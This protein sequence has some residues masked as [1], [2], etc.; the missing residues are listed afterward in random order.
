MPQPTTIRIAK[1]LMV[2]I[3][4]LSLFT[5]VMNLKVIV[6]PTTEQ[7]A[8]LNKLTSAQI[9]MFIITLLFPLIASLLSI[10]WIRGKRRMPAIM[11]VLLVLFISQ[12]D[13]LMLPLSFVSVIMLFLRPS[14]EYFMGTGIPAA[15]KASAAAV[16]GQTSEEEKAAGEDEAAD[17]AVDSAPVPAQRSALSKSDPV[18]D[19]RAVGPESAGTVHHLMMEA[20]EE[21]RATVPPSSA[22]DETVESVRAAM[23]QGQ[24]AA[25]LYEED[26]PVAAVRYEMSGDTIQFFR[27]SVIPQ[28]RRRGYGKRLV[29]WIEHQG[30]SK[31]LDICRCKVRQTVQNNVAMYQDMGYEIVDQELVVRPAGTVKTLTMEK[32]LGV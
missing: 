3:C 6:A 25:I 13:I 5:L 16:S 12:R 21:Y 24:G 29:K 11:A 10:W 9:S 18:V 22:L 23:E 27:L 20:F 30:V 7:Q 32:K 17:Q 1:W 2:I 14:R 4:A 8:E 15:P 26:L 28:R 31:G 19:I